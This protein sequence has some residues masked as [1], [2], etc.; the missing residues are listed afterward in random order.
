MLDEPPSTLTTKILL[1]VGH[2][3]RD[4]KAQLLESVEEERILDLAKRGKVETRL[5]TQGDVST[6]PHSD[7]NRAMGPTHIPVS[8]AS[9]VRNLERDLLEQYARVAVAKYIADPLPVARA[10]PTPQ[11]VPRLLRTSHGGDFPPQGTEKM[12]L[13]RA[14]NGVGVDMVR[15]DDL[16][17]NTH[18][19]QQRQERSIALGGQQYLELRGKMWADLGLEVALDHG[20]AMLRTGT[21]RMEFKDWQK[22]TRSTT[23]NVHSGTTDSLRL[24]ALELSRAVALGRNVLLRNSNDSDHNSSFARRSNL[25][26]Q[27]S[28]APEHAVCSDGG[29]SD[30]GYDI[31]CIG[32]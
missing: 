10:R 22:E 6:F 15:V 25:A 4:R 16:I 24:L 13:S 32:P 7:S 26:T 28:V 3:L 11:G 19:Q 18:Q 23:R 14:F 21:D 29:Y 20:H 30:G 12:P 31:Y 8:P 1:Q 2:A 9:G 27:M 5:H 17:R